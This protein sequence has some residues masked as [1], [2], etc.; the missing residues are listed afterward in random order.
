MQRS[1]QHQPPIRGSL[2]ES[3]PGIDASLLLGDRSERTRAAE[4]IRAACSDSGFFCI[5]NLLAHSAA[6]RKLLAQMQ[7]FFDLP[8][9]DPRK[10]AIEAT[11][12]ANTYGW[13]PMFQEP[14]YQPGTVAHLESFDCGRPRRSAADPNWTPNSWP[15]IPGFRDD[16]RAVWEAFTTIGM[17]TLQALAESFELETDFFAKR[18]DTQD[19]STMRLLHYPAHTPSA[20][21]TANVGIAA[22]TDFECMTL[23]SQTAAGLELMDANGDWYDAPANED[24]LVVMPGD[25]LERW[26]N[27]AC[28]ATG[29]RVRTRG[30]KRYSVV[31]FFA[32]NDDVTVVPH[33][34][35]V[36]SGALEKYAAVTQRDHSQARL[37]EAARNRDALIGS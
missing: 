32:V 11:G 19:L 6:N 24:R 36:A 22:H 9:T 13:M 23:I 33:E 34:Q 3:L 20:E 10:Q 26:T 35:F 21:E 25:M 1:F 37:R 5:D 7:H 18:C 4:Q 16:V 14:A 30:W 27:G 31:L 17:A 12:Q 2:G 8:D 28:R 29:H 15:A